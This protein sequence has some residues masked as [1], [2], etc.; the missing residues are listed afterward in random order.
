M[1]TALLTIDDI[2]SRNTPMLVDYLTEKGIRPILFGWGE[3]IEKY[4]DEALYAVKKG[5]IVGNHSYSHPHFS[6]LTTQQAIEEIEK[7]EAVLNKLYDDAGVERLWRPFRFPYG[8]KGGNNKDAL[9]QYFREHGFHKVDDRHIPYT[10]W[11]ES[12]CYKDIDTFWTFD[13]EEYR[14]AWNDGFTYASIQAKMQNPAPVQGAALYGENQRNILLLHDHAETDAV[15]PG[16][17]KLFIEDML[18]NGIVF[19]EPNFL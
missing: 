1:N 8:D 6:E 5:F 15:L 17:Y 19:D 9:Q 10:W 11:K 14:L 12:A 3:M 2:A 7:C 18:K 4:Y 16:Y 13:F